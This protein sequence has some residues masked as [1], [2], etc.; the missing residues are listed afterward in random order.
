MAL[1][2]SRP[3]NALPTAWEYRW[4]PSVTFSDDFGSGTTVAPE[5]A[6]EEVSEGDDKFG[7]RIHSMTTAE[8]RERYEKDGTIDLWVEEEYNAGSRLT[9]ISDQLG[10]VVFWF[11]GWQRC[12]FGREVWHRNGRRRFARRRSNASCEDPQS[13]YG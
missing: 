3:P 8:W 9:V 6:V 2:R 10:N 5:V 1:Q 13:V 4:G 7:K 12:A 11:L